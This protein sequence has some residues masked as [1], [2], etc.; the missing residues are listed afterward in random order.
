MIAIS[1]LSANKQKI[2]FNI[3]I[4]PFKIFYKP[5]TLNLIN[6]NYNSFGTNIAFSEKF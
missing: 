6:K 2:K 5:K 4:K 3:K 1:N